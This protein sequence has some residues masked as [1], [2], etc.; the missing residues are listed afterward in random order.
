MTQ[1]SRGVVMLLN[2]PEENHMFREKGTFKRNGII[3]QP[4]IFRGYGSFQGTI[5]GVPVYVPMVFICIYCILLCS[6][7]ILGDYNP[8]INTPTLGSGYIPAYPL[9]IGELHLSGGFTC[10]FLSAKFPRV[11]WL[12]AHDRKHEFHQ[13]PILVGFLE[14]KWDP[15]LFQQR[16]RS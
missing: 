6:L 8:L 7:G 13:P 15:V 1:P 9:M 2:P 3:F 11:T 5:E 12:T 10:R 16:S 14:G 4:L